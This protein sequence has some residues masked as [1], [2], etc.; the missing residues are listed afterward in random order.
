MIASDS[1]GRPIGLSYTNDISLKETDQKRK[2]TRLN[3]SCTFQ[4]KSFF[5]KLTNVFVILKVYN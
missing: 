3:K 4:N 2:C 1:D 5:F